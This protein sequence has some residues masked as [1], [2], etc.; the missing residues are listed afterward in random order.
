MWLFFAENSDKFLEIGHTS[1]RKKFEKSVVAVTWLWN[2]ENV[3][4]LRPRDTSDSTKFIDKTNVRI[5][6]VQQVNTILRQ[7]AFPSFV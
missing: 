4:S 5:N 3:F 2:V 6:L 1:A 7:F